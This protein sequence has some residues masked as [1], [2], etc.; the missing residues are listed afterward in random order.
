[1]KVDNKSVSKK[2]YKFS[3]QKGFTLIE[4]L[5]VFA[6]I[7]ILTSLGIASYASYNGTQSVQTAAINL[8]TVLTTAKSDALSQVIPG[9]CVN[10]VSG[11]EVD[12]TP[13][14]QQYSLSVVCGNT[15]ILLTSSQLPYQVTFSAGS[16]NKL[17]FEIST[18][19]VENPGTVVIN[20]Y[21]KTSTIVVSQTGDV[22]VQ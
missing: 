3:T 12:I 13:G 5:V 10:S 15:T 16:A 7:G 2:S 20:G 6:F 1:L 11:Y 18:G 9:Q 19:T 17:F 22:K 21:G 8:T 4:I 14:G